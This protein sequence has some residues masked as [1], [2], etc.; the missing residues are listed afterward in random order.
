MYIAKKR[1]L[2]EKAA[3][4]AV[5]LVSVMLLSGSC[6]GGDGQDAG[7]APQPPVEPPSE[8]P[9]EPP[10]PVYLPSTEEPAAGIAMAE[11]GDLSFVQSGSYWDEVHV[12]TTSENL[13]IERAPD[14]GTVRVLVVAGGG[15]GGGGGLGTSG[16]G[17]GGAGGLVMENELSLTASTYT[18]TVGEGGP[19]GNICPNDI[20][21]AERK[22]LVEATYNGQN[23]SLAGEGLETIIASGGGGGGWHFGSNVSYGGNGGSGGGGFNSGGTGTEGQGHNGAAYGT[24]WKGGGGGYSSLGLGNPGGG[25]GGGGLAKADIPAAVDVRDIPD[26][27]AAGGNGSSPVDGAGKTGNG[28]G[29]GLHPNSDGGAGGSGIVIVRFLHTTVAP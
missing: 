29:G 20:T 1:I 22:A 18:V 15:G 17:G 12:F 13:T 27:F 9:G 10:P 16:G 21:A 7:G 2:S 19:G 14:A 11:G 8:P 24:S 25:A 28:G 4:L 23:S 26:V 6:K 3:V 5:I